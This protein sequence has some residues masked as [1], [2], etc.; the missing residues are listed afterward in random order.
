MNILKNKHFLIIAL[1]LLIL[2]FS[3][4]KPINI[5]EGY[6]I[7]SAQEVLDGKLLYKDFIFHQ[8]PVT[9]YVY[10]VISDFGFTS[11]ILGRILSVSMISLS[12]LLLLSIVKKII[13]Q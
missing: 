7:A 3:F 11:L 5:D 8:M 4:I 2:G 12:C 13:R 10:S 9:I 6:Y 1:T